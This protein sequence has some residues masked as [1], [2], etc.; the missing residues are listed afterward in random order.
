MIGTSRRTMR[1]ATYSEPPIVA[2]M[3]STS[4]T[5]AMF[6]PTTLPTAIA[7]A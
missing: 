1:C 6:D 2:A 7:P 4:S 5:L 3:P